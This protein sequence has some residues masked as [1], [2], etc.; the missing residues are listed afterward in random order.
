MW[1]FSYRIFSAVSAASFWLNR[2][3]TR[4]GM[5]V[6]GG[7]ILTGALGIDTTQSVA[8]QAFGFLGSLV[9][10]AALCLPA[11]RTRVSVDREMPRVVTAGKSFTYRVRVSNTGA[12]AVD[13][14]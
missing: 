2:R 6:L 5:L 7:A 12:A 11:L 9:V 3:L 10:I 13:G 4:A 1:R 14:L 8:Y